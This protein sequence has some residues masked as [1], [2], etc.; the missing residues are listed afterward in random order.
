MKVLEI[1][2]KDLDSNVTKIKQRA[3]ESK[4]IAVLKGNA[5]GLGFEE[6]AKF[7]KARGIT[8]FAV[9]SVSEALFLSRLKL[10]VAILC[11]EATSIKK[12]LEIMLEN[13]IVMTIGTP[14]SAKFLN[15]MAKRKN[16]KAHVHLKVDTGFSRYG[17]WYTEKEKILDTIKNNTSLYFD[18]VFSHFSCAYFKNKDYTKVQFE[19][20][21]EVKEYLEENDVKI[22]LYHIAN[23]SAFLKYPEMYLDAVRLGSA[24]LGRISVNN[25]IGLKRI[26]MLKSHVVELKNV[27]KG[28]PIGY[29]NSEVAKKDMKIAIIPVGYADGYNVEI[30]NDTF[31]F[32][33]RLRIFKNAFSNLFKNDRLYVQIK[34]TKY[35]VIGR[36]GMNHISV[37]VTDSNV[38]VED[39]VAIE[40]SPILVNSNIRREYI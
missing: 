29:S 1:N 25:T 8:D 39:V 23:S 12:D 15:E 16:M 22:P 18:G 38:N 31:K 6:F 28:M 27:K 37:D 30:G 9:S 19:R 2:S 13:N 11:M 34:D 7:M 21:M 40:I 10:D 17:F 20:F 14:E 33:D 32:M 36:V 35:N 24:F 4:I 26:G 5:Y 3:G